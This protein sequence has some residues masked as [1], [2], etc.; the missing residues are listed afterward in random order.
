LEYTELA[1]GFANCP[2]RARLQAICDDLG[3]R[4]IQEFFDRWMTQIPT[5]LGPDERKHGYWWE[6]SMRQI[7]VSRTLAFDVPRRARG[8]VE[9]LI[10]DN[11]DLGGSFSTGWSTGVPK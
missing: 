7:E 11:L 3:P 9:A 2:N 6:L 1:N 5:P 4:Q 8:F 10:T